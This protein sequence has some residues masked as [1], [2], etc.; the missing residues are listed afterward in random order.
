MTKR[1]KNNTLKYKHHARKQVAVFIYIKSALG[2]RTRRLVRLNARNFIMN[3][4]PECAH[5]SRRM[6]T[7][8]CDVSEKLNRGRD[9]I[10]LR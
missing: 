5:K 3:A 1:N 9:I 2:N 6:N 10:K 4:R 8:N 7:S